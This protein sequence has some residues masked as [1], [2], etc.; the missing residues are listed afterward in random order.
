[1]RVHFFLLYVIRESTKNKG[2]KP[3]T[4]GG[5]ISTKYVLLMI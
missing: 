5:P 4:T 1:M 2:K 3:G